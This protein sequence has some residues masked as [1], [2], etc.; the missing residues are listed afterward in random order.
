LGIDS[1]PPRKS[2]STSA[3]VLGKLVKGQTLEAPQ[4]VGAK[5]ELLYITAPQKGW[6][7]Y[8]AGVCYID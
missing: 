7:N 1:L 3:T 5:G 8:V 4:N 2:A 6:I